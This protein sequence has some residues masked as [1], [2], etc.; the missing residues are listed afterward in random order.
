MFRDNIFS[1]QKIFLVFLMAGMVL[2][3]QPSD[4][5]SSSFFK[6]YSQ[7]SSFEEPSSLMPQT[8][9]VTSYYDALLKVPLI[10]SQTAIVGVIFSHIFFQ[11]AT[12]NKI[13]LNRNSDNNSTE[14]VDDVNSN[15][16]IHPLKRLFIILL[17]CGIAMLISATSLFL[18]QALSLSSELGLD[19]MTT[20]TILSS[21]PVGPVWNIRVVTSLIIIASSIL[22]YIFEKKVSIKKGRT[23]LESHDS[24]YSS[25]LRKNTGKNGRVLS[26]SLLYITMIA[27]AVSIF[28]NSMVSHNT[29]LSFLPSLA[30]SLDWLHF[31]AVSM[32]LGGL[33]YISSILLITIKLSI[34]KSRI[35]SGTA[36]RLFDTGTV[37]GTSYFLALLLPYFSLIATISL[38]IIGVTGLYMAW[39]HLHTAEAI[40]TS[41]YGNI[42]SI[43]LL[44]ILPMVILGGYHQIRLHG[45]LMTVASFN[46]VKQEQQ[47]EKINTYDMDPSYDHKTNPFLLQYDPSG[48]FS[49]TI[50]IE[51]L[52]GIGVLVAA[53]FLTITSPPSLSLQESM[54][55]QS[56]LGEM[57]SQQDYVPSLDSFAILTII[58]SIAVV[59]G[60]IIYYKK[61]K[62]QVRNTI[63]YLEG[64]SSR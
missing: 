52:I 58:L 45:S 17:S 28:S 4:Y 35:T 9:T 5:I 62:K 56:S 38:G 59:S 33:F 27:G 7:I 1:R 64:K 39:I 3:I 30:I 11:R 54:S 23:G 57:E 49:K 60:S 25:S 43:K 32:W 55:T 37:Y 40:F 12:R 41:P 51:S 34:G 44:L 6:A 47:E 16:Y 20:F 42:L 19:I 26:N 48:K 63:S 24:D 8:E 22:Y 14:I 21:T 31:M 36:S 50:K 29:A 18:L 46:K 15:S 61:S 13:Q 2:L 53:S 10:V